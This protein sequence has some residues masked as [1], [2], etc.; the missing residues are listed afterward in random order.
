[1]LFR[2]T[3]NLLLCTR[4]YMCKRLSY[5]INDIPAVG[6]CTRALLHKTLM[7]KPKSE[8]SNLTLK[9]QT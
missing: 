1:M 6:G 4:Y 9:N 8:K 2:L 5:E 7:C 3:D